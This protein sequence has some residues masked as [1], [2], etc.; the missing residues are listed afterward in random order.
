MPLLLGRRGVLG[1]PESVR[2]VHLVSEGPADDAT[3]AA[4]A[5]ALARPGERVGITARLGHAFTLADAAAH[6]WVPVDLSW[7]GRGPLAG[8]LARLVHELGALVREGWRWE[9]DGAYAVV[10]RAPGGGEER[11]PFDLGAADLAPG[12]GAPRMVARIAALLAGV[13]A[14][15]LEGDAWSQHGASRPPAGDL[16]A[17]VALVRADPMPAFVRE[18]PAA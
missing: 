4:V 6:V 12:G 2:L 13:E 8:H 11:L 10:V 14:L 7:D 17:P 3:I 5:L 1:V 15:A 18:V 16:W 9:P